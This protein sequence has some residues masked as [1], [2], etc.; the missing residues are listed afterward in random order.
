MQAEQIPIAF[1][2]QG[3]LIIAGVHSPNYVP[4]VSGWTI[5]LDGSAEFNNLSLRGIFTGTN[6]V[7]NTHGEFFYSGT[8]ALGNLVLS[9]TQ[10]SGT[11]SFG[12][13][14]IDGFTAYDNALNKYINTNGGISTYGLI[15]GGIPSQVDASKIS[16]NTTDFTL[17]GMNTVAE[18]DNAV[19]RMLPGATGV[20]VP[21]GTEPF[22]QHIDFGQHSV[23]SMGVSGALVKTDL[24]G[25]PLTQ[26]TPSLG[27]NWAT[28]S[29][30]GTY[31]GIT[32]WKDGMDNLCISGVFHAVTASPAATV[33]TLNSGY[34][35][36]V[37]LRI[38][39][40]SFDSGATPVAGQTHLVVNSNGVIG[41]S[42]N[43]ALTAGQNFSVAA[44][45]PLRNVP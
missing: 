13:H 24:G 18:P 45:I 26:I 31:Q 4:G 43:A 8:P 35:L 37:A 10:S 20:L 44:V 23:T 14:Y 6:Y 19:I 29:S 30:T 40:A 41:V 32:Y 11:D 34:R 42:A 5:N 7:I 3:N 25:T 38:P 27:T 28:Q 9:I 17:I 1:D 15:V 22:I 36:P 33:F 21:T 16:S 39:L 2:T 12:N